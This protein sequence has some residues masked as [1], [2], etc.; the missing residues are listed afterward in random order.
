MEVTGVGAGLDLWL[1]IR[2]GTAP[3]GRR[4]KLPLILRGVAFLNVERE[5]IDSVALEHQPSLTLGHVI[6]TVW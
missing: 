4:K 6:L 3:H 2:L 5:S 1:G